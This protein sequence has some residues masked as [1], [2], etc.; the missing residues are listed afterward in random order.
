MRVFGAS[1]SP[2]GKVCDDKAG[3]QY[4]LSRAPQDKLQPFRKA[5]LSTSNVPIEA[6]SGS[7]MIGYASTYLFR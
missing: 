2:I 7:V 6:Y 4:V 3:G 5:I 1:T